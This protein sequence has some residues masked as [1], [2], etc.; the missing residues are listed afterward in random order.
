MRRFGDHFCRPAGEFSSRKF[1]AHAILSCNLAVTR[2]LPEQSVQRLSTRLRSSLKRAL[3]SFRKPSVRSLS[4]AT[5]SHSIPEPEHRGHGL[6]GIERSP[7][8]TTASRMTWNTIEG[9][10]TRCQEP[11]AKVR[12]YP[13]CIAWQ[14][15]RCLARALRLH[16]RYRMP[17]AN[18]VAP[19]P[20]GKASSFF[21]RLSLR[22]LILHVQDDHPTF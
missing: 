8:I 2:P 20:L 15:V 3:L 7:V 4:A 14:W 17:L 6:P 18:T 13:S 19:G 21:I 1:L 9:S 5:A 10:A 11:G 12:D 16:P 22:K